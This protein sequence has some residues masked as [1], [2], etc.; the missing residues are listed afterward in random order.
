MSNAHQKHL[1]QQLYKTNNIWKSTAALTH[2]LVHQEPAGIQETQLPQTPETKSEKSFPQLRQL[3]T[4]DAE[5]FL[6]SFSFNH[7]SGS[8]T[9]TRVHTPVPWRAL[10]YPSSKRSISALRLLLIKECELRSS[11]S[12]FLK[13]RPVKA[14]GLRL[15]SSRGIPGTRTENNK[16][17]KRLKQ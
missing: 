15:I 10:S 11:I 2:Q 16:R 1:I 6:C 17:V 14:L 7:P 3:N 9:N 5:L 12:Q 4:R 13:L 8:L